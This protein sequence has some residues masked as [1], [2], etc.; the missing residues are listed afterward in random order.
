MRDEGGIVKVEGS[1]I[2]CGVAV[3]GEMQATNLDVKITIS[4]PSHSPLLPNCSELHQN[5][6]YL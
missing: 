5:A 1:Q 2:S 4:F 6:S 3:A